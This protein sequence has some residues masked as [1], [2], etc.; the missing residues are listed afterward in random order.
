MEISSPISMGKAKIISQTSVAL[1]KV[2]TLEVLSKDRILQKYNNN[3]S[4]NLLKFLNKYN[5]YCSNQ[6]KIN[7]NEKF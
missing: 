7:N 6:L 1:F 5:N 4:L 3:I 2:L